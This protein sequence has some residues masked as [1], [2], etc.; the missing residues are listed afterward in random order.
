MNA[1]KYAIASKNDSYVFVTGCNSIEKDGLN[2]AHTDELSSL[3]AI[4]D[5]D[6]REEAE[7]FNAEFGNVGEVV[8]FPTASTDEEEAE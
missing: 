3:D 6:S 4:K 1:P 2:W 5:F 8:T 7:E